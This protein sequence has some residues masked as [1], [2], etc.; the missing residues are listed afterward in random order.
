MNFTFIAVIFLISHCI[1]LGFISTASCKQVS[2]TRHLLLR[3]VVKATLGLVGYG[4]FISDVCPFRIFF[5]DPQTWRIMMSR[6]SSH[7]GQRW[8]KFECSSCD[9]CHR[10]TWEKSFSL[11]KMHYDLQLSKCNKSLYL[12]I[13]P[14]LTSSPPCYSTWQDWH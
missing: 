6:N 7:R 3:L 9:F 12:V 2:L 14:N 13:C 5:E 8:R 4:I 11:M 1:G 10:F